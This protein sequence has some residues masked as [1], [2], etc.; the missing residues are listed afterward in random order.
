[1]KKYSFDYNRLRKRELDYKKMNRFELKEKSENIH[2]DMDEK[3][4]LARK[5]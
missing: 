1:M 2:Q 5:F 4:L 3:I